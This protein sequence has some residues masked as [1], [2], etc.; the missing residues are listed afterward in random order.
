M[1]RPRSP[2][3]GYTLIELMAVVSVVTTL[4]SIAISQVLA[5]IDHSR[6]HAAARYLGARL[7]LARSQAVARGAAVGLRF[8]QVADG[9]TFSVF[10]DGN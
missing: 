4:G 3:A 5:T 6:G 7:G 8:D 10:V 1:T 9:I 2:C